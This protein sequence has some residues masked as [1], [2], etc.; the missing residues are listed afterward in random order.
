MKKYILGRLLQL[1]PIILGIT[2][3]TFA[4]V[5]MSSKDAVDALYENTGSSASKVAEQKARERLGLDQPF[6]VQYVN[7]LTGMLTGDMGTSFVSGDE[8]LTTFMSKLPNTI[9]L[10]AVVIG[11]TV[12]LSVPLGILAAI[13]RNK[14]TDYM[15]RFFSFIG[16]SLPGFFVAL[17]L[18]YF[19]SLQLGWFSVVGGSGG[20]NIVLPAATLAIAMSAKYTRQVRTAVLEE[21]SKG[22]V[23]GASARGVREKTILAASILKSVMLK[24]VTLLSLSIGS[25]LGGTAIV[26]SIFMWDGVGKLAVD[27]I[28]MRDYPMILAYVVW[29][30]LI[31]VVI[32]LITDILYHYLDP[33]VRMGGAK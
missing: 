30:A 31:Y 5:Q 8:V 17:L 9:W 10:T 14:F 24:I 7:W 29:M 4:L 28:T 32:N 16:N 27:S 22:Y 11:M 26:E 15:I 13:R 3:L 21:L 2:F 12:L 19:F 6:A 20:K 33:R 1:I 23:T 18:I 25:L